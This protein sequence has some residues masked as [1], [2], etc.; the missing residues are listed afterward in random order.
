MSM[1]SREENTGI[2]DTRQKALKKLHSQ[3]SQLFSRKYRKRT[4][5]QATENG[6]LREFETIRRDLQV[7]SIAED[8]HLKC[9]ET[10]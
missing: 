4:K 5:Y 7:L 3:K 9:T 10:N 8:P 2:K 1:L 6:H